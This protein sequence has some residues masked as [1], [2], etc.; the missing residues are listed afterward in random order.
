[1]CDVKKIFEMIT[2]YFKYI[3]NKVRTGNTY[4]LRKIRE[5]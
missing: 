3:N 2:L 5:K 1:M 4:T